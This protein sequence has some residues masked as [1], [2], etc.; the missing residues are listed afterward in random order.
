MAKV[1]NKIQIQAQKDVIKI[2]LCIEHTSMQMPFENL[3][4]NDFVIVYFRLLK[5][6]IINRMR[7]K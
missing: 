6:I 3:R 2:S 1:D 5:I 4:L 7:Y